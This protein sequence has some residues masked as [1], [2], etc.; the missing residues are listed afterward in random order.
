[1]M[2]RSHRRENHITHLHVQQ[3]KRIG[4]A[5]GS[6][7]QSRGQRQ[8]PDSGCEKDDGDRDEADRRDDARVERI[9]GM[10]VEALQLVDRLKDRRTRRKRK[11]SEKL[12]V[13]AP[14]VIL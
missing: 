8:L 9:A 11:Y 5:A 7:D 3:I 10:D 14:A 2:D 13:A 6:E 12:E 4:D 1:M